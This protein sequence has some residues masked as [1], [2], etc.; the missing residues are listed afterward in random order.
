MRRALSKIISERNE[1]KRNSIESKL[2]EVINDI[3][4]RQNNT[5]TLDTYTIYNEEIW[6]EAKTVMNG[7]DCQFKPESFYTIEFGPVSHKY[8]T[9]IYKSKFKAEPFK[10]GSGADTKRGLRFSKDV[11]N[12]LAIHYDVPNEIIILEPATDATDATHYR[13]GGG[14]N[15]TLDEGNRSSDSGQSSIN[16]E[17]HAVAARIDPIS[18]HANHENVVNNN[19]S[20]DRND[21]KLNP[22]I[23]EK[24]ACLSSKCVA[25]VA[26]VADIR[27]QS[28]N[29]V[30]PSSKSVA[31]VASVAY[32]DAALAGLQEIPC[33]WCDYKHPIEFD[34]GNHLLANHRE[35]LLKLPIGKGSMDIRID[36][37][38]QQTKRKMAA[39]YDDEDVESNDDE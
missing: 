1:L 39:Q 13:N 3:I 35:Q 26:S 37:V 20:I 12:R 34:L 21:N 5:D 32:N 11:L 36:Y 4:L 29:D 28:E 30:S 16:V 6:A 9:S 18:E 8:I 17:T 38:I 7:Q 27:D 31:S 2:R 14:Q 25:S 33:A 15:E 19:N 10:T 22:E 23:S 24:E